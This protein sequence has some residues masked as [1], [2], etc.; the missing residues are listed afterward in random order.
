VTTDGVGQEVRI[1]NRAT[2]WP[3]AP[4]DLVVGAPI[5][6]R[7]L[8]G[9]GPVRT[10]LQAVAFGMYAG[11]ALRDWRDRQAIRRIDFRREFCADVD[12]LEPMTQQ[13]YVSQVHRLAPRLNDEFTRERL[14][15]REAAARVDRHL[16]RYIASITGQRVR[17]SA[18]VRGFTLARLAWPSAL[19]VCDILSGDVAIF[20][21][22]GLFEPHVIAHE[23]SH[24][25]G[26]WKELYA[27]V[28]A[29]LAL[30]TSGD[31]VLRQA[32]RCER[33]YRSLRVLADP[34]GA[35]SAGGPGSYGEL[36]ESLFSQAVSARHPTAARAI[37][38]FMDASISRARIALLPSPN[39]TPVRCSRHDLPRPPALAVFRRGRLYHRTDLGESFFMEIEHIVAPFRVVLQHFDRQCDFSGVARPSD[40]S[41]DLKA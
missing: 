33:V 4:I 24:R 19:G 2:Y 7:L 40:G 17:T 13:A 9:A 15:R 38:L 36:L 30:A 5:V 31:P 34:G 6:A 32:A 3:V 37:S 1:S 27:Q 23:F 18:E 35:R 41:S 39:G 21:D 28:L 12:H 20:K 26:Y 25:K 11:S 8:V 29:Y 22:T 10:L 14:S 16:T